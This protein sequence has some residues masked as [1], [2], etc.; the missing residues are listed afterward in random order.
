MSTCTLP[1]P[2]GIAAARRPTRLERLAAWFKAPGIRELDAR[3]LADIR[4][5]DAVRAEA[6]LR[7]AWHDLSGPGR[8]PGG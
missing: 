6:E 5:S 1:P 7:R 4:V 3:T 8:W 2:A